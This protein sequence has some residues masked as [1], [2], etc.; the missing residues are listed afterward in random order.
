MANADT[1][2]ALVT[3]MRQLGKPM[4]L[5]AD[6]IRKA[7]GSDQEVAELLASYKPSTVRAVT[8]FDAALAMVTEALQDL[9]TDKGAVL[10]APVL[11]ALA[12]VM[13]DA[14]EWARVSAELRRHRVLQ[15]VLTALKKRTVRAARE[16]DQPGLLPPRRTFSALLDLMRTDARLVDGAL[17]WN[18][19]QGMPTIDKKPLLDSEIA[20]IRERIERNIWVEGKPLEFPFDWIERAVE[21]VAEE[22]RYNPVVSY[23]KGVK[24]D[25]TPRIDAVLEEVIGNEEPSPIERLMVR[26][27]FVGTA[28]RALEPGCQMDNAL[29]LYGAQGERKT[30]LFRVLG[31]EWFS[32]DQVDIKDKD[33]LMLMQAIWILEWGE[34][35]VLKGR[36]LSA[37]KGFLT[38]K[39]DT[40]R[41]PYG[42]RLVKGLRHCVIVGTTNEDDFLIDTTGNR[43]FWVVRAGTVNI[44]KAEHWRDQLWAEA[45]YRLQVQAEAPEHQHPKREGER[46]WLEEDEDGLLRVSQKRFL[47]EDAIAPVLLSWARARTSSFTTPEI[48]DGAIGLKPAQTTRG[49]EMAVANT[50]KNHDYLHPRVGIGKDRH[51]RW[52]TKGMLDY[53]EGGRD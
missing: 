31:G 40:F 4:D 46:W 19:M 43:R 42:R 26:R 39:A 22:S 23:L 17:E 50:L 29:I 37:V 51:R 10:E 49:H 35:D 1:L 3:R 18:D 32:D 47:R 48:L 30:S 25:G 33:A 41:P 53:E 7:G 24:W 27:W 38:K 20:R 14:P 5:V 34:L 6:A 12:L 2:Q 15:Q 52:M 28:A 11:E 36:E 13:E 21:M 8:A 9:R 45:V 16:G 44:D